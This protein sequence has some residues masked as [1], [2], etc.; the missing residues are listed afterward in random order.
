VFSVAS[1]PGKG[2]GRMIAEKA[3]PKEQELRKFTENGLLRVQALLNPKGHSCVRCAWRSLLVIET[4][5]Y[6]DA[7]PTG[8]S[9]L[10][11]PWNRSDD[12][13]HIIASGKGCNHLMTNIAVCAYLK[14]AARGSDSSLVT[15][16]ATYGAMSKP[17]VR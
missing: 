14:A 6:L 7:T 2:S 10:F 3:K 8:F 1:Q 4:L 5:N 17:H 13:R 16:P 15:N 11:P 9:C 12:C